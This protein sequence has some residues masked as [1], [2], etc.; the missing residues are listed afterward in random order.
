MR[1]LLPT[2][3]LMLVA[4]RLPTHPKGEKEVARWPYGEPIPAGIIIGKDTLII[5]EGDT[6]ADGVI[7]NDSSPQELA[8]LI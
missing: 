3:S 2:S 1:I 4:R 7:H 5:L 8:S 6:A